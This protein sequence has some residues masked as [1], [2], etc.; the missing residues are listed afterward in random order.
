MKYPR[1]SQHPL[2]LL[3]SAVT[4]ISATAQ[5]IRQESGSPRLALEEVVVTAQRRAQSLRDVPVAVS[6]LDGDLLRESGTTNLLNLQILVPSLTMEQNKGPGFA[7]FRI[8]G[9]GNLGNIPNFESAVGL[10]IDGAYRS[11]SGL[12]VGELVD[13]DRV[14]VLRGPQSTLYGRNVTAG[15]IVFSPSVPQIRSRAL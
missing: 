6:A 14:E 7:T 5:E 12:G 3:I 10:F 9:V 15:L 11:K 2:A 8:R 1:F 13:V 4:T